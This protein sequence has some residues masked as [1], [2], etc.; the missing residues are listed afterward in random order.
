LGHRHHAHSRLLGQATNHQEAKPAAIVSA[1]LQ[2]LEHQDSKAGRRGVTFVWFD[3]R[4]EPAGCS[5]SRSHLVVGSPTAWSVIF[6]H[7]LSMEAVVTC[8]LES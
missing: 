7:A 2:S 4:P 6:H 3:H 8:L 5:P 1:G